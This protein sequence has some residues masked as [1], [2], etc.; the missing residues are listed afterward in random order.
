MMSKTEEKNVVIG[1][2]RKTGQQNC[3]MRVV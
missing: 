1:T 3:A 2:Q